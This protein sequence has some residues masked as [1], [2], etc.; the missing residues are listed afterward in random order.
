MFDRPSNTFAFT[1]I[2]ATTMAGALHAPWWAA[3][4]GACILVLVSLNKAWTV[5]GATSRKTRSVPDSIQFAASALNG[6]AIAA[7]SFA[8]GQGTTWAWGL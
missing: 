1:T 7:A 5:A 6:G 8:F 3:M 4:T 2:L